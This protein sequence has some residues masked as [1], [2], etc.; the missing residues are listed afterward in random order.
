MPLLDSA[1][2]VDAWGV[3][4]LLGLSHP[5]SVTT[6]QRRYPDMPHPVLSTGRGRCRLWSAKEIKAW[7]AKRAGKG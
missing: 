4:E 1:D 2:L 5:N 6:Y 3:A 7:R